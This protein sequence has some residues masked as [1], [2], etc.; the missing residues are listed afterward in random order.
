[1]MTST[2]G[3]LIAEARLDANFLPELAALKAL[4]NGGML[5]EIGRSF[6]AG[7]HGKRALRLKSSDIRLIKPAAIITGAEPTFGA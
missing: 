7:P 3:L 2:I 6:A 4:R 5:G 1:M